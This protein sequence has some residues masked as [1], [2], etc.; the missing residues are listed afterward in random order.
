MFFG[1]DGLC[2]LTSAAGFLYLVGEIAVEQT[3]IIIQ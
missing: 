1:Y 2:W 3:P